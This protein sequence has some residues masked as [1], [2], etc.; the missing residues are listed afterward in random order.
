MKLK[1]FLHIKNW[2]LP[3]SD[4]H[5]IIV[6]SDGGIC[7]QIA[8]Q[9][10][11]ERY[12]DLGFD[13]KYDLSWFEDCGRDLDGNQTRNFQLRAAF[14]GLSIPVAGKAEIE[15]Y[16]VLY[17]RDPRADLEL[18]R[19][20]AYIGGYPETTKYIM[21]YSHVFM[22][23]FNPV[24][25]DRIESIRDRIVSMPACAVH[26][27]RGDLASRAEEVA[28]V[29]Y[30]IHA[31]ELIRSI[32]NG[33]VRFWFFSDD[34]AYVRQ[35]ILPVLPKG[36][37]GELVDANDQ[38]SGYLDLWLMTFCRFIVASIGSAGLCAWL[39]RNEDGGGGALVLP[40]TGRLSEEAYTRNLVCSMRDVIFLNNV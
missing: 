2:C 12:K 31:V 36:A 32:A 15:R 19:P 34:P 25:A 28:S 40:R 17:S 16:R 5:S 14:P 11:G 13:V 26:V 10:L 30:F 7:S 22:P 29:E 1:R 23:L 6:R 8:F 9:A 21:Q 24:G 3:H 35:E 4:D 38:E 20:P 27:R 18:C 33:N 39:L 37:V